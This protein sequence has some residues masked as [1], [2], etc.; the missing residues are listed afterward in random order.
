[1]QNTTKFLHATTKP[2]I[3]DQVYLFLFGFSGLELLKEKAFLSNQVLTKK[4]HLAAYRV[5]HK[6]SALIKM[7]K[8]LEA[9]EAELKKRISNFDFKDSQETTIK[10]LVKI[11]NEISDATINY[12]T[13]ENKANYLSKSIDKLLANSARVNGRELSQI[14]ADAGVSISGTLKKTYEELVIFHNKVL[15][16][17]ILLIKGDL[18]SAREQSKSLRLK[19]NELQNQEASI[20]KSIK[21]PDTLKSIGQLYNNLSSIRENIASTKALLKKIEDTKDLI[22]SLE[23]S[24][25]SIV[26]QIQSNIDSL[27]KNIE[28]FNEY[29]GD[30][31]KL[32]Y[33]ERYIFDLTFDPEKA[34]CEFDIAC[35]TPNSTGGKK[36]GELSAFDMAYIEFIN[37]TKLKRPTFV[38]HDSI[39]D[40]DINQ[41]FDIFQ[42]ANKI[43]G[44]YIV[45][46][47]SDKI[48]DEKFSS[49]KKD[50]VIL[51]L[52][53][54]NKFFKI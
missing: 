1:M 27:D 54:K 46:I 35:I 16:N 19:I 14:Y 41:V 2:D 26:S 4:K 11:Q 29:F 42:C 23:E 52:S 8:P 17:K 13:I 6:E 45:A 18:L 12:S 25:S 3:Y 30:L 47:L 36:K 9:E 32:F 20:F 37:K 31:S 10:E 48:S 24:K 34:K 5:P 43:N 7:I 33:D 40:V 49:L 15:S 53:E 38:V 22:N 51:E 44:Q 39:E 50:S 21:E 28:L